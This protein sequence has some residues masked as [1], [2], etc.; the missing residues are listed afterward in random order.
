MLWPQAGS[1]LSRAAL[2]AATGQSQPCMTEHHNRIGKSKKCRQISNAPSTGLR[3]SRLGRPSRH[4]SH[5][6]GCVLS[7][8]QDG[9]E[10]IFADPR[11]QQPTALQGALTKCPISRALGAFPPSSPLAS[12]RYL[13]T[14]PKNYL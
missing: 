3:G 11:R 6:R 4:N 14:L 13:D 5:G 7:A 12:E 10:T 8:R 9:G 1:S 2:T